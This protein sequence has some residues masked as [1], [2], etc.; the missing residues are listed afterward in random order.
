[1]QPIHDEDFLIEC[2]T[3]TRWGNFI[4]VHVTPRPGCRLYDPF[5]F[6]VEKFR[7]LGEILRRG[8]DGVNAKYHGRML[9]TFI[10]QDGGELLEQCQTWLTTP[11]V[12]VDDAN[13]FPDLMGRM[14]FHLAGSFHK[15][16]GKASGWN[17]GELHEFNILKARFEGR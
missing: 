9:I 10:R 6:M 15:W 14:A 5:V 2:N 3:L 13:G 4:V 17:F 11:S 7:L 8:F 1:M 16:L 12:Q